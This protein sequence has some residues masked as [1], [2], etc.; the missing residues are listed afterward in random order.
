MTSTIAVH[1]RRNASIP[2]HV[3][4]ASVWMCLTTRGIVGNVTTGANEVNSAY[5]DCVTM[6]NKEDGPIIGP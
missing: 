5:M 4:E 3:V 1:A 2:R 6:H